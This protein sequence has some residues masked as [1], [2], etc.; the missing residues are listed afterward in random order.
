MSYIC[1]TCLNV[2]LKHHCPRFSLST[3]VV[4][5][6]SGLSAKPAKPSFYVQTRTNTMR[7]NVKPERST[8]NTA[9]SPFI[10]KTSR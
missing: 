4:A 5:N 2:V 7:E 8:A 3:K 9:N 1:P 10:L 6:W